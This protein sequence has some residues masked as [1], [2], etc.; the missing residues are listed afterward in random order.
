M[1]NER[2]QVKIG[3][4]QPKF[5]SEIRRNASEERRQAFG[6]IYYSELSI[7]C[8]ISAGGQTPLLDELL[9]TS[10]W[11]SSSA[12]VN[13][14]L[15]LPSE[16]ICWRF[17]ASLYSGVSFWLSWSGHSTDSGGI[18]VKKSSIWTANQKHH[19]VDHLCCFLLVESS[20]CTLH[21]A[22]LVQLNLDMGLQRSISFWAGAED[23]AR[24]EGWA[25]AVFDVFRKLLGRF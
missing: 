1:K 13:H 8:S 15:G 18:V 24:A 19:V 22:T 4:E 23:E 6:V 9:G 25:G 7:E 16:W 5:G 17:S 14:R 10:C 12:I 11:T 3:R 20:S 2:E 21:E